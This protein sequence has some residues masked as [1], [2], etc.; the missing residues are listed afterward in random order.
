MSQADNNPRT[1]EEEFD[2]FEAEALEEE[3]I[4][5]AG[6]ARLAQ[7]AWAQG[8]PVYRADEKGIFNLHEDGTK[9]YVKYY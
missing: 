1:P 8:R 6:A 4:L 2:R 9:E 5:Q 7:E 3:K